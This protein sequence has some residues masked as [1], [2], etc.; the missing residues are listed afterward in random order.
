MSAAQW[1]WLGWTLL[2]GVTVMYVLTDIC[3]RD[4]AEE[5]RR[6]R[7]AFERKCLSCRCKEEV[8]RG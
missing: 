2:G 4:L 7:K 8:R 3:F 6:L 5:H 1:A